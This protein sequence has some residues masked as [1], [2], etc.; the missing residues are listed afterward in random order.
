MSAVVATAANLVTATP[1]AT[2]P[3]AVPPDDSSD[4]SYSSNIISNNISSG[5]SSI[6]NISIGSDCSNN[7][8]SS[9]NSPALVKIE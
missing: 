5:I 2:V 7:N 6:T 1:V 9:D 8:D 3:P 4:S